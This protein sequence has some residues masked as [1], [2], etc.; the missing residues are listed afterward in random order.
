VGV[1]TFPTLFLALSDDGGL[2][3]PE[4][5]ALGVRF[6]GFGDTDNEAFDGFG[7]GVQ[8]VQ[9]VTKRI[10]DLIMLRNGVKP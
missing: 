4:C 5:R 9:D 2:T 1:F 10:G 7:V 6:Y 3:A 8:A